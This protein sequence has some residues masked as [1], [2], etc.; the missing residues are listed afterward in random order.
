MNTILFGFKGSGKTHFGKLLAER[1]KRPFIDTDDLIVQ[2]HGQEN[3]TVRDVYKAVGEQNFRLLETEALR[4]LAKQEPSVIALGGGTILNPVN[5]ELLKEMG[6]L[7]YLEASL[8]SLRKREVNPI[9]GPLEVL[10]KERLPLYRAIPAFYIN[11]DLF[12][13]EELIDLLSSITKEKSHA[14]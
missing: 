2:L 8:S 3:L 11:T 14:L 1:L 5:K 12:N 10:Y 13:E 7:I 9:V 4:S 6:S